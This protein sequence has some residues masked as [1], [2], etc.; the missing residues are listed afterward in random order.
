MGAVPP[1]LQR[2]IPMANELKVTASL[3]VGPGKFNTVPDPDESYKHC[4][5]CNRFFL[6]GKGITWCNLCGDRLVPK[7]NLVP[8]GGKPE[9]PTINFVRS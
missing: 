4:N 3:S 8:P 1:K 2:V 9:P 6:V 7:T 5:R